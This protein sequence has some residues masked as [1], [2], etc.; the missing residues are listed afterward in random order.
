MAPPGVK[1]SVSR[2]C[3]FS[4]P[5]T[6]CEARQLSP[7]STPGTS[8]PS[9]TALVS[10][11]VP[12]PSGA[13][14]RSTAVYVPTGVSCDP[15][16]CTGT[17]SSVVVVGPGS[18]GGAP[19]GV[20]S[21][22]SK[23]PVEPSVCLARTPGPPVRRLVYV[24]VTVSPSTRPTRTSPAESVRIWLDPAPPE[25]DTAA[26][27]M[28]FSRSQPLPGGTYSLN[29]H[30]FV[31]MSDSPRMKLWEASWPE[32]AE[33]TKSLTPSLSVSAYDRLPS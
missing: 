31:S 3:G 30:G 15:T 4:P 29:T 26:H 17:P 27:T 33:R 14:F 1:V 2:H 11:Q 25:A 13:G 32:R 12:R 24:Q 19:G 18:A 22:M 7:A 23:V 21:P 8:W 28:G 20:S 10:S 9:Q 5:V 16:T 6:S